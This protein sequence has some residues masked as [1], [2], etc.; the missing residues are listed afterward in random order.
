LEYEILYIKKR[1]GKIE[2]KKYGGKER[3]SI[4]VEEERNRKKNE[5]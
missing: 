3:K 1:K 5:N 2:I 4:G